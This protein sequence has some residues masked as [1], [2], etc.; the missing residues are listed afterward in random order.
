[1][2]DEERNVQTN[3]DGADWK[4]N[5]ENGTTWDGHANMESF[6]CFCIS[7]T[8]HGHC[9]ILERNDELRHA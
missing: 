2:D 5:R 1:M 8:R 3:W 6:F 9:R 4:N 7:S